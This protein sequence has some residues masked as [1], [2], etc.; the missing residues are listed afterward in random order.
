MALLLRVAKTTILSFIIGRIVWWIRAPSHSIFCDGSGR[1]SLC[2]QDV[3]MRVN[4]LDEQRMDGYLKPFD[5]CFLHKWLVIQSICRLITFAASRL[6]TGGQVKTRE[7]SAGF[8]RILWMWSAQSESH[9]LCRWERL[10]S[11]TFSGTSA[12]NHFLSDSLWRRWV[13]AVVSPAWDFHRKKSKNERA[14]LS[15]STSS[16]D[17]SGSYVRNVN[18][19]DTNR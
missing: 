14:V 12:T 9:T 7:I 19:L 4:R 16:G 2:H 17:I 18:L 13:P 6:H 8:D 10:P 3:F 11:K 1:K 5:G 15:V